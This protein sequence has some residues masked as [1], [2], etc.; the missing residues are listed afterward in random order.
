MPK[1]IAD[2]GM[3]QL[4]ID[5]GG[6]FQFSAT[7]LD[8]LGATE[9]TLVTIAVDKSGSVNSFVKE[10]LKA[11]VMIIEACKKSPRAENLMIRLITFNYEL[12]EIHGFKLLS[13]IDTKD[14]IEPN[15]SSQTA[16]FDAT[17]SSIGATLTYAKNLIDQDFNAN[18]ICFIITDGCDNASKTTPSMI[19][20]MTNDAFKNEEIESLITVLVGIGAPDNAVK[21]ELDKF[22]N[23]ARLT[24]YVDIGDATPQKLAKLAA[25]VSKS[26]SSQSSA[27]GSGAASQPLSF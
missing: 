22:F 19:A 26:I 11:I 13:T 17:Y 3:E 25:F 7:R 18:G 1:L 27:L 9:Y 2:K 20:E 14:Y 6:N 4:K 16:L 8:D 5:G 12:E 10:L 21:S 24:Q 15:C 23:V